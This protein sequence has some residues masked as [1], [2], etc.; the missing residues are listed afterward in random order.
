FAEEEYAIAVSK[1]N[2]ALKEQINTALAELKEEGVIDDIISNYIGSSN[3][4][5]HPYTSPE[6]VDRSKGTLT[7]ATNPYFAPYEYYQNSVIIGIDVDLAQAICD[8][9]GYELAIKETEFEDIPEAVSSGK[10]D[11]GI[12]AMSITE[13]RL[14]IIDFSDPYTTSSQVIIVRKD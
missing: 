11:M 8:K 14:K 3:R 5:D 9:L 4:G 1:D 13:D 2:P 12:A 6:D 10:V 7:M